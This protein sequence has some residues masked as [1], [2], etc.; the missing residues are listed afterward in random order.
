MESSYF[1]ISVD[2]HR[3]GFKLKLEG[4]FDASSAYELIHAIRKLPEDTGNVSICTNGL[5]N[6]YPFGV[7]VF[8]K[9]FKSPDGQSTKIAFIGNNAKQ[10]SLEYSC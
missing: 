1:G 8:H 3:G 10:L 9:F 6:I 2:K 5:N 7:D 4:D